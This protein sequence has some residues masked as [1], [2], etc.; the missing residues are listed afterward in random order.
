MSDNDEQA[1]S[2]DQGGP[3]LGRL[4]AGEAQRA[5]A[6]KFYD[7][8][9][10]AA[11]TRNYD[12]A[13]KLYVDGLALWPDA[14]EEGLK[15]L[16]V[17]STA[18]RLE[19]GKP[20]GFI[21]ARKY[22][23]GGRD[24]LK[25]LKNALYLFGFDPGSLPNIEHIL[26][27]ATKAKCDRMVEWIAPVLVD[28]YNSAKKLSAG[29]YEAACQ[30][31]NEASDLA[32]AVEAD[33]GATKILEANIAAAQ[34]WSRHFPNSS[35]AE[36]AHSKAS[37]KLTIVKGRFSRADGFT[38]S[39][40]DGKAQHDL[41]DADKMVH[42]ED[43]NRELIARARRVWE[44]NPGVAGKLLNLVDLMVRIESDDRE[45]EAVALL[46]K[47]YARAGEYLFKQ[48]ADDLRMRQI[49]RH[50]RELEAQAQADPQNTELRRR[51]A[52]HKTH[53][54]EIEIKLFQ[55]RLA[56]YPTDLK[57]HFLL[58]SR[59]FTAR[60]FDDAI[61]L[62][63]HSQVDGRC[64]FESRLYLGRCFLEKGFSDQ[65]V[66]TLRSALEEVES[67]SSKMALELQYWLARGLEAANQLSEARKT[68]GDLIQLDYNYRDARRR[69]EKLAPPEQAGG[70]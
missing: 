37:S 44:D 16:R 47:E 58:G 48:K 66:G 50:R 61:P 7:H 63:Q 5:K 23:L 25:S 1:G 68:Y 41:R 42:T 20:L 39:L 53:Q 9:K 27:L 3:T 59:L 56:H 69:L 43:R 31:L 8:A 65:A 14:I 46:E 32:M 2:L 49:S 40:K 22:P 21:A 26:Q 29:R 45:N 67:V 35:E 55:D 4:I 15:K 19:G 52:G 18:R 12:Y 36:R 60:R 62:F 33:E 54:S 28:A 57:I 17:V 6:K 64:R 70:A 34:I 24:V 51:L 10:K 11:D 13:I 38:E 30:D